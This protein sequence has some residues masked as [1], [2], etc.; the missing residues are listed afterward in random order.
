MGGDNQQLVSDYSEKMWRIARQALTDEPVHGLPHTFAV[1]TNYLLFRGLL[2]AKQ[3]ELIERFG[4]HRTLSYF[5]P[6][7]LQLLEWALI[8]HDIG[9]NEPG[10]H[11]GNSARK[12][13]SI[14]FRNHNKD[15]S[16]MGRYDCHCIYYAIENHSRGLAKTPETDGEVCLVL[17]TVFDHM[18][19][20]GARGIYRTILGNQIPL[21]S[22][23]E[24][25]Q[26]LEGTTALAQDQAW[27]KKD[28]ILNHLIFNHAVT[29]SI[30]SQARELLPVS[31]L[32]DEIPRRLK[33]MEDFIRAGVLEAGKNGIK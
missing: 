18:D 10:D 22:G 31:L 17:L 13:R 2:D 16:L 33:V 8:L 19:A 6:T 9:R 7:L 29:T 32:L 23:N 20:L 14:Y 21:Y 4:E 5:K 26:L 30:V 11:A 12:W 15:F 27:M 3:I 28:S 25:L 24:Q 1:H